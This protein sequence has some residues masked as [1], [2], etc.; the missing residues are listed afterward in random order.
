MHYHNA[1]IHLY[2]SSIQ[3]TSSTAYGSQPFQRVD[4]LY[5]CLLACQSFFDVYLR[6]PPDS[7]FSFSIVSFGQTAHALTVYLKLSLLEAPGWDVQHIR[8][9]ANISF[10]L[11]QLAGLFEEASRTI[12]PRQQMGGTDAFSR[13]VRRFRWVKGWYDRKTTTDSGPEGSQERMNA[14]QMGSFE[15]G[16]TFNFL[17]DTYWQEIIGGW[18]AMPWD[19]E[20]Q[21]NFST[22]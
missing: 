15:M 22:E 16:D 20:K 7:F 9:N 18:D 1:E 6:L 12:D 4:M 2:E 14:S 13:C 5:G 17:D 10:L 3:K 21:G 8:Q 11:D 19:N